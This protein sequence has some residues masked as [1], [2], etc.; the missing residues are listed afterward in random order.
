MDA[1]RYWIALV[2]VVSLVPTV[3]LWVV[4]HPFIGF[5]RRVGPLGTYACV[6]TFFGLGIYG[7]VLLRESL[8]AVEFGTQWPLVVLGASLVGASSWMRIR[9]QRHF[10]TG[11]LAGLPELAPDRYPQ[12]LVTD[13]P[14]GVVRHP[15][16]MQFMVALAGFCLIANYLAL[17]AVFALWIPGLWLIA[18][19]EE[20]ELRDRF[21]AA[22]D[23]YCRQV[24]R[25]VPRLRRDLTPR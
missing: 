21:G 17:Y 1:A 15:R 9:I 23:D 22:Y 8:L 4:I 18:V 11:T 24:P 3:F 10:P 19:L 16:Y 7:M 13:G 14:F 5:W 25:F 2:M 12:A 20:R 6:L